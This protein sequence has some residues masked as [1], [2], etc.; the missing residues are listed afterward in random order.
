[1]M[2]HEITEKVGRYKPVKRLGRGDGSGSGGTSGRG[3][4][5]AKSRSGFKA[6]PHYEGGQIPLVK[7]LPKRG[8]SN[9]NFRRSFA[10]VNVGMLESA[11][12][13]G[14]DVTVKTVADAGL[15]RDASLPLKV[16]GEGEVKKKLNVTAA[17]F[18]ASAKSKIEAAGG[19]VTVSA[20]PKWTRD[21]GAKTAKADT[22]TGKEG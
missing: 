12:S 13:S 19:S 7:R 3:H 18:S 8:F 2:I 14:A 11:F 21:A 9:A 16:L 17:K 4:K 5:G 20:R 15:I 22:K 6:R 10:I 1:M